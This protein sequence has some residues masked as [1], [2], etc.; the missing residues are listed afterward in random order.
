[1]VVADKIGARGTRNDNVYGFS[2]S[3]RPLTD[4]RGNFTTLNIFSKMNA[5]TII[6]AYLH[7]N[8]VFSNK[9]ISKRS[10]Q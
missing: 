9:A 4:A 10:I 5:Y 1:M 6:R 3:S 8:K 2:N 7:V